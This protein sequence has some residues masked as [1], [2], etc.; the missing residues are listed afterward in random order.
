MAYQEELVQ[1]APLQYLPRPA[2][3]NGEPGEGT[4]Q[5]DG[6]HDEE[7]TKG[8][9]NPNPTKEQLMA[10]MAAG[11]RSGMGRLWKP[12]KGGGQG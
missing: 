1:V 10:A 8:V 9:E 7:Y 3:A 4:T 2:P 6:Q 12:G 11:K 5:Y